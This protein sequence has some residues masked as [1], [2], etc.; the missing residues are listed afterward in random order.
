MI[1]YKVLS[2]PKTSSICFDA[3][4]AGGNS[5][6][7]LIAVPGTVREVTILPAMGENVPEGSDTGATTMDTDGVSVKSRLG[8]GLNTKAS[9]T[10]KKH[11][12]K[13]IEK[14]FGATN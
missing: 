3:A 11:L 6:A 4:I 10:K 5:R 1:S 12:K 9:S 14:I 13:E 2:F 7:V 8:L